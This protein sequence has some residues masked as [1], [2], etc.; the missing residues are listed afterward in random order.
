MKRIILVL[1]IIAYCLKQMR[2]VDQDTRYMSISFLNENYPKQLY[3]NIYQIP[4]IYYKGDIT[5][6]SNSSY[7]IHT[8][9]PSYYTQKV[10]SLLKL[11]STF[12]APNINCNSKSKFFYLYDI[13]YCND[14]KEF[15][16]CSCKLVFNLGL[17]LSEEQYQQLIATLV[18]NLYILEGL[19]SKRYFDFVNDCI[20]NSC[21]VY[22]LP[23]NIFT[24][25]SS[26]PNVMI[27]K[28]IE[29]LMLNKVYKG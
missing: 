17:K 21:C 2:W 26:L 18:N 12:L 1:T 24:V 11:K 22:A 4:V 16:N 20:D 13:I 7:M 6:L 15:E 14:I 27:E 28:G 10:I 3:P 19:P 29:P 25:N 9:N 8:L 23:T 5:L